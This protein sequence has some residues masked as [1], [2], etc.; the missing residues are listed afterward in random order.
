MNLRLRTEAL[1]NALAA[2]DEAIGTLEVLREQQEQR[3]GPIASATVEKLITERE[4]VTQAI[5]QIEKLAQ[6]RRALAPSL[7]HI[8][9]GD[10][11]FRARCLPISRRRDVERSRVEDGY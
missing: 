6:S 11:T 4:I 3:G 9:A 5:A 1:H 10:L 8:H 2:I 7:Q